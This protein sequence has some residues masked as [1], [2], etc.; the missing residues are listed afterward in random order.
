VKKPEAKPTTWGYLNPLY[1]LYPRPVR[2]LSSH[3]FLR[4]IGLL[5]IL[6]VFGTGGYMIIEGWSLLDALYMTTITMTTIGYGEVSSL[7][8]A[9]RIFTIGLI[10]IGVITAS[11]ALTATIERL[12]SREFLR[13]IRNRRRQRVLDKISNHCII[14]GF[15]RMGRSLA[16]ELQVRG[17][18]I[19][20]IDPDAEAIEECR[21]LDIPAV[22]GD[23][24]AEDK[25][26][27]AGLERANSLVTTTA[28][29]AKN[30]FIVLTARSIRPDLEIIARCNSESSVPTLEKA[31]VNAVISPYTIA[32]QRIARMLTHPNVTNFL[33]GVLEFGDHQMRLEEFVIDPNSHLA[34]KTLREAK[35]NAVVLAVDHPGEAVFTHPSADTKLSPGVAFIAMGIDHELNKL[36]QQIKGHTN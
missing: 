23:A 5:L 7:S 29:D 30:V 16:R 21:Q 14:C 3:P 15:G 28:S 32:G 11:Y 25:L 22:L 33:D 12:T 6:V 24:S 36:A 17:T 34:G 10:V 9:G 20:V 35:L 27:Q 2:W 1:Y 8:S 26:H 18:A 13:Q 31:G 19:I 4:I